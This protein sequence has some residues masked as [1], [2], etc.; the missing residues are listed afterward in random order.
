MTQSYFTIL[1]CLSLLST[2]NI[3]SKEP[4]LD[5]LG[6]GSSGLLAISLGVKVGID[7]LQCL[8][9][10]FQKYGGGNDI[11][12]IKANILATGICAGGSALLLSGGFTTLGHAITN[13]SLRLKKHIEPLLTTSLSATLI[14]GS[15]YALRVIR[16]DMQC[17]GHKPLRDFTHLAIAASTAL[18]GSVGIVKGLSQLKNEIERPE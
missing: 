14:G 18:L 4:I 13:N 9:K 7:S 16:H 3:Q 2:S 15:A 5:R 6:L 1:F 10:D 12:A 11:Q 8:K 17:M